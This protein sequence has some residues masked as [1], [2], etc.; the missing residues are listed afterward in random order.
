MIL[1]DIK[2][3][4]QERGQAS[5]EDIALHFG[6]STEA[7]RGMLALLVNKGVLE[8]CQSALAC[9]TSCTQCDASALEIYRWT[10]TRSRTK[11]LIA[12]G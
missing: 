1:S 9:G 12:S 2:R 8:Q 11:G 10:D 5:L 4:L 7:T 6:S 3:Y